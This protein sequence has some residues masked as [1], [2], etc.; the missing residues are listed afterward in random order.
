M[1]FVLSCFDPRCVVNCCVVLF[2]VGCGWL[3]LRFI[4]MLVFVV[5]GFVCVLLVGRGLLF[6]EVFWVLFFVCRIFCCVYY[7][8][9]V[10]RCRL[11]LVCS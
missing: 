11:V 9:C 1:S 7:S 6:V 2:V 4:V 3:S 8:L 5:C 10:V